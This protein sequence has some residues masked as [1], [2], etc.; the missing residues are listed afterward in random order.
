M[1]FMRCILFL[2]LKLTLMAFKTLV[3]SPNPCRDSSF[4]GSTR[5]TGDQ[6]HRAEHE[7]EQNCCKEMVHLP[8]LSHS[9]QHGPGVGIWVWV[10]R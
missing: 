10:Q 3:P 4:L 5:I 2:E 9:E 1:M 7:L 8:S 6:R